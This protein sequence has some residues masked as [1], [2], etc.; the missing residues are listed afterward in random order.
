MSDHT[1]SLTDELYR[2]LR[3]VSLREPELLRRLRAET[4][5]LDM[6]RMQISP[7]QGQFMRLVAM[8]VGARK[9]IEIGTFTG[10]SAIS[11]ALALPPDGRLVACDISEEWTS[12]AR[13]YWREAGVESRI[14]LHL[15]PANRTLDAL[16]AN[17]EAGSFDI[18][19]IDADKEGYDGYYERC[20]TLLRPGGVVM[21]DN[22][23]W[24]GKVA[25]PAQTDADTSALRALNA[26]LR[27]DVRVDVSLLPIGDGL[28][29]ARKRG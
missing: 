16:V 24:D 27:D 1:L 10:Y 12:I 11:V 4:Q 26:K 20:L 14:E 8:L 25:D 23:L 13:R 15:T 7:E 5:R 29:L 22:V 21:I 6:A 2:Y 3:D 19:F 18:A 17:G 28:T 9:A